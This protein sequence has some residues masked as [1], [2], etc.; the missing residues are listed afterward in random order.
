MLRVIGG[1]YR[2]RKLATATGLDIRPTSDRLRES[3][4]NIIASRI[5]GTAFLDICAGSG[6]IGIEALSRGAGSVTFVDRS[7]TACS[8]IRRNLDALGVTSLAEVINRGAVAALRQLAPENEGKKFDIVFFDPPYESGLYS[9]V[10]ASL[11]RSDLIKPESLIITEY[12]AKRAP[13]QN[14]GLLQLVR[15]VKHGE[16]ALGFYS[17]RD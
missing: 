13:E 17:R 16:S 5:E 4:F 3:L 15:V 2:G 8:V 9:P 14:Y 6:A 11:S 12:R 1:T 10:L 7:R